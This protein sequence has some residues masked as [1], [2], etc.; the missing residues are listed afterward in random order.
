MHAISRIDHASFSVPGLIPSTRGIVGLCLLAA[1]VV[2]FLST[3]QSG[4][5]LEP[6]AMMQQLMSSSHTNDEHTMHLRGSSAFAGDGSGGEGKGRGRMALER[7][8]RDYDEAKGDHHIPTNH[9]KAFGTMF[10]KSH[11]SEHP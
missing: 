4:V 9:Q 7:V 2:L 10:I 8:R 1:T 6:G 3:A 11:I 5:G